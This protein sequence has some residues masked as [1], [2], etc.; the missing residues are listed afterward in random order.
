MN[1]LVVNTLFSLLLMPG[2]HNP[3][4]PDKVNTT[5]KTTSIIQYGDFSFTTNR[6]IRT[7]PGLFSILNFDL[8]SPD[9]GKSEY[10]E[11]VILPLKTKIRIFGDGPAIGKTISIDSQQ[12]KVVGIIRDV[13]EK[14]CLCCDLVILTAELEKSVGALAN[15]RCS[16][17]I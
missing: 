10:L 3:G 1:S 8:V 6:I 14:S 4:K 7:S 12:V 9:K 16:I 15:I 17:I 13:P 5:L 2:F 11:G